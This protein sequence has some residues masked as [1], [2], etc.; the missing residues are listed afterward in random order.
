MPTTQLRHKPSRTK[1]VVVLRLP[2][3]GQVQC[4]QQ[5]KSKKKHQIYEV[6]PSAIELLIEQ[7][8]QVRATATDNYP[9][10]CRAKGPRVGDVPV[11][12]EG[13]PHVWYA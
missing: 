10:V 12:K 1:G 2:S 6:Q 4:R 7:V 11:E 9:H 8:V 5:G 13:L 3:C